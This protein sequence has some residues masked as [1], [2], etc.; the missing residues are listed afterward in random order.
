MASYGPSN[1]RQSRIKPAIAGAV[2][3]ALTVMLL[4]A[5]GEQ[6]ASATRSQRTIEVSRVKAYHSIAE[7][8]KD[9]DLVVQV[10]PTGSRTVE[11]SPSGLPSTIA[12]VTVTRVLKGSLNGATTI[13]IRQI[14]DG[15]TAVS[16]GAPLMKDAASYL[17][18]AQQFTYGPDQATDQFVVVGVGA[19]L[20]AVDHG[21]LVSMDPLSPDLPKG[22]TIAQMEAALIGN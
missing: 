3:V 22:L 21:I 10:T 8:S 2:F 18:F 17:V 15:V 20:F 6:N 19:G 12:I 13:K 4:A 11:V 5:C 7:L 14:G 1:V 16:D 9:A